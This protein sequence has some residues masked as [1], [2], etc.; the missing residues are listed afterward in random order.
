MD[1]SDCPLT[2]L[3]STPPMVVV[4]IS[5][6]ADSIGT[7]TNSAASRHFFVNSA[8]SWNFDLKR[9]SLLP[10]P[11]ISAWS[12]LPQ[13]GRVKKRA[14]SNTVLHGCSSRVRAARLL[15]LPFDDEIHEGLTL[16]GVCR[17]VVTA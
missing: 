16:A 5:A 6:S 12:K 14:Q 9:T 3:D 2:N 4:R 11:L 17:E 8:P 13:A 7:S 1:S 15:R 10:C